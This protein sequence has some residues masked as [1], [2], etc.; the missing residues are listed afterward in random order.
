M[1]FKLSTAAIVGAI[2]LSTTAFAQQAQAPVLAFLQGS[3][4]AM[5]GRSSV[6]DV[7]LTGSVTDSSGSKTAIGSFTAKAFFPGNS[8][9]DVSLPGGTT[10]EVR[11]IGT[12]GVAGTWATDDGTSHAIPQHNLMTESAWFF[13][14]FTLKNL[15]TNPA[16]S[17]SYI[18]QEGTL[19]HFTAY[20]IPI[21]ASPEVG[22]TQRRLSQIDIYLDAATLLPARLSFNTHPDN[23]ALLDLPVDVQF[24]NYQSANGVNLPFRI[25]KFLNRGLISDL[26]VQSAAFNTGLTAIAISAQ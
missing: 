6:Q 7:T 8:R 25:Q 24:F 15:L 19:V 12:S 20:E 13:P 2:A 10:S 9:V 22:A 14:A 5:V 17:V 1:D 23:N 3:L 26:Q 11:I 4:T 18:G 21:G 16:M